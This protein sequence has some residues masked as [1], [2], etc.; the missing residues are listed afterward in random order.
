MKT[1]DTVRRIKKASDL[2]QIQGLTRKILGEPCW[3]AHLSYG[4]ELCLDIGKKIPY[5][6]KVM[7]GKEKGSWI[8]GCRASQWILESQDK[9]IASSQLAPEGIERE[10]KVVEGSKIT[11]FEIGYPDLIL[12]VSFSNGCQLKIFPDLEDLDLSYWE[13]FTPDAMLLEMGPGRIWSYCRADVPTGA[14]S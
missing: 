11:R 14:A 10:V 12:I 5:T 6:Q 3:N 9:A 2:N 13:L 7:L 8:L 4:D 1:V